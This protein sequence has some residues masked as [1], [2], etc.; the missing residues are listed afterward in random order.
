[1]EICFFFFRG[2]GDILLNHTKSVWDK[3]TVITGQKAV[4]DS[5]LPL[6]AKI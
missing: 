5:H 3:V 2:K 1:M 6:L 4:K